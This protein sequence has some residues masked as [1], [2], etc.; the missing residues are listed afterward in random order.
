MFKKVAQSLKV[1]FWNNFSII[2][3]IKTPKVFGSA[4][5]IL[6]KEKGFIQILIKVAVEI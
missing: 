5:A 6:E 3:Q 4:V 2:S 1:T